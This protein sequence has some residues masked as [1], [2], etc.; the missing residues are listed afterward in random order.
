VANT[1]Y[2]QGRLD[3]VEGNYDWST[4]I[5]KAILLDGTYTYDHTST[6]LGDLSAHRVAG[7]TDQ[8]LGGGAVGAGGV[9]SA[10]SVSFTGISA[11]LTVKGLA[12]YWDAGGGNFPLILYQDTGTGFP[13]TTTGATITVDWNGTAVH[14]TVYTATG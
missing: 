1:F 8:T 5:I 3:I 7:S 14:G 11:G 9:A 6:I 2:D 12:L 13:L 10:D 4:A